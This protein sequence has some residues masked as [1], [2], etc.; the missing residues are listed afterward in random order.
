[1]TP[2]LSHPPLHQTAV[3]VVHEIYGVNAH[4]T[5]TAEAL[6]AYPC[7]VFTPSFLPAGAV[8][9]QEDEARAYREF[10]RDP[11]LERMAEEL[12]RFIHD[13]RSRYRRVL[14]IGF[15]VG[16]T[17]AWLASAT[18][19]LDGSVCFYGSRIRDH[20]AVQPTAPCLLL[21]AEHEPGFSVP[22]VALELRHR[23]H[24]TV[25]TYPCRHGF[26]NP[27]SPAHDSE[28]SLQAWETAIRFLRLPDGARARRN[29]V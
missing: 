19:P 29:F 21:F 5:A 24:V 6:R 14:C 23:P 26:C 18:A 2:R 16:A 10:A 28:R 1:M 12:S 4:I 11:G 20:L 9:A 8:F 15:S 7:D 3:V 27:D 22:E 13:L 25:T 17:S